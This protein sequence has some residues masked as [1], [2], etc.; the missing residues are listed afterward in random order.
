MSQQPYRLGDLLIKKHLIVHT[1]LDE[2]LQYQKEHDLQLGAA[3]IELGYVTQRQINRSLKKQNYI[4]LYAACAAFFMAPFSMCQANND[5]IENLPE[6]SFTQ[7]ADAQFSDE[8][9]YDNF[10]INQNGNGAQLDLIE[11]TTA[12]AWYFSQAGVQDLDIKHVP[13]KLNLTSVNSAYTMNMSI[14]F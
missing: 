6:Y 1:Q 3:L 2:A 7:V 14:S 12:A 9:Q 4:R 8:Y 13:V 5:Q 10:G 11:I